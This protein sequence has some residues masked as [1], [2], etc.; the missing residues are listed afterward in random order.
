MYEEILLQ[1]EG[2]YTCKPGGTNS[3]SSRIELKI[4]NIK[5]YIIETVICDNII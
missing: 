1:P 3:I 2:E 5:L 4:R